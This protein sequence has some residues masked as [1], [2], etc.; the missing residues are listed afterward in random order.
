MTLHCLQLEHGLHAA[1]FTKPGLL[2]N[3]L[4]GWTFAPLFTAQSG[5]PLQVS[6]SGGDQ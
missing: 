6:I 4:G 5:T 2:H 3:V 1:G